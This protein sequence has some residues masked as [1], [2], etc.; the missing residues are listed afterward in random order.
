MG[1]GLPGSLPSYIYYMHISLA[2]KIVV[3]V[4]LV[5]VTASVR[6]RNRSVGSPSGTSGNVSYLLSKCLLNNKDII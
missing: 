2:N 4:L 6:R 5:Y 1:S 3:V